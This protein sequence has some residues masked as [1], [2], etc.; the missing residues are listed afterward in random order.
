[1]NLYVSGSYGQCRHSV[2]VYTYVVQ[3]LLLWGVAGGRGVG[4][5]IQP[6]QCTNVPKQGWSLGAHF[7]LLQFL[8]ELVFARV[9]GAFYP[10]PQRTRFALRQPGPRIT[11]GGKAGP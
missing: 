10:G 7:H 8:P 4:R 9:A 1:M 11:R 3:H 2:N 6:S 5:E